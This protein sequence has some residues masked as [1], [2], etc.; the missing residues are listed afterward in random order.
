MKVACS[1]IC[2]EMSCVYEGKNEPWPADIVGKDVKGKDSSP[3]ISQRKE[4]RD[5]TVVL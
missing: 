1:I 4:K 2:D 5:A 3:V